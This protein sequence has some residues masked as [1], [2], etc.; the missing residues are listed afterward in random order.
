MILP[1]LYK[2]TNTGKIQTWQIE[3]VGNKFRTLTGQQGG[4]I[5]IHAWNICTGKNTGK[6]NETTDEAQAIA[7][8]RAKWKLKLKE[9]YSE[10]VGNVAKTKLVSPMLA[11]EYTEDTELVYPVWVQ[12]KLD[13]VRIMAHGRGL[14]SRKNTPI[15]SCPHISAN[16][17]HIFKK[18]PTITFDGEAYAHTLKD[19]F[20]RIISLVRKTKP[21]EE[22]LEE[23]KEVIEYWIYD[24]YDTARPELTFSQRTALIEELFEEI[25]DTKIRYSIVMVETIKVENKKELDK[26]Y[27][28]FLEEGFE[29]MMIRKDTPYIH[30]RTDSLLKRKEFQ[31]IERKILEIIEGEGNRAGGAGKL[32][33]EME[34]GKVFYANIVGGWDYYK[35]IL[36]HPE[37]FLG[38]DATITFQNLTPE[39]I[40]RF[41]RVTYIYPT[42][43][44]DL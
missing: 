27:K 25:H 22:E 6:T 39:G 8:A 15:L 26:V 41:G 13:G 29:G 30:K 32:K 37:E 20:N 36:E 44:R 2:L 7:E 23:S 28:E 42:I 9:G 33:F 11:E 21:T 1:T 31:T 17:T 4:R 10:E 14:L 18:Y 35:Y 34:P 43:D 19:N 24:F 12:G 38:H 3:V 40:P 5:I 16:L